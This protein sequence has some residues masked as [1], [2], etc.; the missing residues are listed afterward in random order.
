VSSL[1]L[2]VAVVIRHDGRFLLIQRAL[3]PFA[4][5]WSPVTGRVEPGESLAGAAV[6]EAHEEMGVVVAP[7]EEF[8]VCP[9]ADGSHELHFLTAEWTGGTPAPSPREVRDW[10]WFTLADAEAL[11][12]IFPADLVALRELGNR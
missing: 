10:G 4:G 6:R 2:A 12:P 7:G 9:T 11:E 1:P 8:H 3:E 5:W